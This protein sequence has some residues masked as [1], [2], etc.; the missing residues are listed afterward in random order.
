MG[1][2]ARKPEGNRAGLETPLGVQ[3]PHQQGRPRHQGRHRGIGPEERHDRVVPPP[4]PHNGDYVVNAVIDA[5]AEMGIRDLTL[6]PTAL[7]GVHKKLIEHIKMGV[8]RRIM[9]SVNGPIGQMVSEGAWRCPSSCA[10]TGA[11]PGRSCRET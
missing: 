7:F 10:A 9:G 1:E 3:R 5:C 6:F 2:H 8:I 11:G 4:S